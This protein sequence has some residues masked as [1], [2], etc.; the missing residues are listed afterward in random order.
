[1]RRVSDVDI[2]VASIL[3]DIALY[4]SCTGGPISGEV[5]DFVYSLGVASSGVELQDLAKTVCL[6]RQFHIDGRG[7]RDRRLDA[8]RSFF[9]NLLHKDRLAIELRVER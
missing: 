5:T 7:V 8:A 4:V 9:R 3:N 1:M 6:D 2:I